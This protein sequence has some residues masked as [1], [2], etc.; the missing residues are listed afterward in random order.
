MFAKVY[1]DIDIKYNV[2]YNTYHN[3]Y[4]IYIM[5]NKDSYR[6]VYVVK[7]FRLLVKVFMYWFFFDIT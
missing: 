3:R 2:I 4:F 7:S 1:H 6:I 5:N